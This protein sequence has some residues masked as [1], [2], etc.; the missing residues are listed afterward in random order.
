MVSLETVQ[1]RIAQINS[2]LSLT[3][4]ERALQAQ[5]GG[6]NAPFQ[7]ALD[8]AQGAP[9]A[10]AAAAPGTVAPFAAGPAAP[11]APVSPAGAGS[12]AGA[13]IVAA[14][15]GEV[16]QAEMPPGSNDSPRIAMYRQATPGAV[17]G[18][19]CAYFASW[20]ARQAGVPLGDQGQGFGRVDDIAAWAKRTGR[21]MPPSATPQPG[22]LIIWDEHMGIVESVGPDGI[23]T[24]EGNSSDQVSRRVHPP[25][26]MLGF[27]RPG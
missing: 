9:A 14:A 13:R 15:Q 7:L 12:G 5:T 4:G 25:G 17:V 10:T 3:Q 16:G 6:A 23:R 24:I 20:A 27:V 1:L 22:D 18:P 26:D 19:W 21:W 2:M 8:Q 11:P